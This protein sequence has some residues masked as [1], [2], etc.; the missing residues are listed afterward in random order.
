MEMSE[1]SWSGFSKTFFAISAQLAALLVLLWVFDIEPG[2]GV[3]RI[4]PLLFAGFLVHSW[5]PLRYRLQFFLL[6]SAIAIVL[7]LGPVPAALLFAVGLGLI[8][9]SHLPVAFSIRVLLV[10]AVGI[11]LAAARLGWGVSMLPSGAAFRVGGLRNV[12]LP[13]I[14]SMFVFRLVIYLYDL[15]HEERDRATARAGATKT[16]QAPTFWARLSYFF[17]LPNVCFLLFPVVDFRTFRRTYYDSD[18][19]AIYW[20]GVWLI[21]LG[22]VDLL[23]YRLVYHF[24][25]ISPG[26]IDGIWSVARFVLGRYLVYIRVVGQFHLIIGMLCLFGFNLPP[27][28]RYFFLASGFTDFWRRA[29]IDWK[30]FMVK[31]F[32]YPFLVPSQR[33]VGKTAA[34][35]LATGLVFVAT[36]LLHAVQWLWLRG[37]LRLSVNDAVFWGIFGACVLGNSLLEARDSGKRKVSTSHWSLRAA[38]VHTLKV[39]GMFTFICVLWSYWSS[40]SLSDWLEDLA[41]LKESGARDYALF[42]ALLFGILAVGVGI[43]FFLWHARR[44]RSSP[45]IRSRNAVPSLYDWRTTSMLAGSALL[46]VIALPA[47]KGAFGNSSA[48]VATTLLTN[49]LN[50]A[51]QEQQDRGY[52]ETLLDEPRSIAV[53]LTNP[54]FGAPQMAVAALGAL[55]PEDAQLQKLDVLADSKAVRQTHDFLRYELRP[56]YSGVL[57]GQPFA[58]NRWGMHDK[59]YTELPAPG[60]YR[61]ALL[62]T[63]YE[64]A[65]GI[66]QGASFESVVEDSLNRVAP[67]GRK[68]EILNFSVGGYANIQ[69]VVVTERKVPLFK[70]DV[71]IYALHSNEAVAAIHHLVWTVNSRTRSYP[72][73]EQKLREARLTPHMSQVRLRHR[74]VPIA[75]DIVQWSFRQMVELCHQHGIQAVALVVP[76]TDET[77]AGEELRAK[78]AAWAKAAGFTVLSLEGAYGTHPLDSVSISRNDRHPNVLGHK[79][80]AD[81][82]YDLLRGNDGTAF[83]LGFSASR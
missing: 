78:Y 35:V 44:G 54:R 67:R 72:Y 2:S 29:R 64:M 7:V 32:Y 31:I 38:L 10:S 68:F 75:D 1:S 40:Q 83:H 23:L 81:R 58:T 59:E 60:T 42:V 19:Q 39:M 70:P 43:H 45:T 71:V 3:S 30:D 73:V 14:G 22:F 65:S 6:L 50:E 11:S 69:N 25:M 12:V 80:L 20:K 52:Y 63:S 13:V 49:R 15:R 47:S 51:D 4:L 61:I 77:K 46:L 28:H 74:L 41:P 79:L 56:S 26:D 36:L 55:S 62:G 34:L 27:A 66:P 9:L 8:G 5:L 57:R 16:V 21:W 18:P 24:V 53:G 82:F 37:Q 17:L 33:K 48:Q 76:R